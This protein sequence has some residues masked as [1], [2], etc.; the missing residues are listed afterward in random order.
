MWPDKYL[1]SIYELWHHASQSLYLLSS[2]RLGS[3][4][5]ID[6]ISSH[7]S[8]PTKDMTEG[9]DNR[10]HRMRLGH[11]ALVNLQGL[12]ATQLQGCSWDGSTT[13]HSSWFGTTFLT[14]W[15]MLLVGYSWYMMRRS[16]DFKYSPPPL[17]PDTL[18]NFLGPQVTHE[19]TSLEGL[20]TWT[21]VRVRGRLRRTA[22]N[23]NI[24]AVMRY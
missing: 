3:K 13:S 5:K 1:C 4:F 19:Y 20:A 6:D 18:S 17:L 16:M 21:L 23:G 2:W 24:D 15:T 10:S 7:E 22:E 8:S 9:E 14:T 11:L 12:M